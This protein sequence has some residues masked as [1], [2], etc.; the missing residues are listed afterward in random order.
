MY[1]DEIL[2]AGADGRICR[3]HWHP[4]SDQQQKE[5][6]LLQEH[7]HQRRQQ[8]QQE[9]QSMQSMPV[10]QHQQQDQQ[11]KQHKQQ[12]Q[13]ESQLKQLGHDRQQQQQQQQHKSQLESAVSKRDLQPVVSETATGGAVVK[14]SQDAGHAGG[15]EHAGRAGHAGLKCTAEE[16]F[17]DISLVQDVIR[18]PQTKQTLVCGFK[19][20]PHNMCQKAL[21]GSPCVSDLPLCCQRKRVTS[22]DQWNKLPCSCNAVTASMLAKVVCTVFFKHTRCFCLDCCYA[23]DWSAS[24]RA[25]PT[26]RLY[27]GSWLALASHLHCD[28]S[29]LA[30]YEACISI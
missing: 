17:A 7:H 14:A 9:Q 11:D 13:P 25:N 5:Q 22:S 28:R 20:K 26:C 24:A 16:R 27:N 18:D 21:E 1:G 6:Q 23:P 3:Y 29:S 8:Q 10:Q 12:H 15:A 30:A 19:V 4:L 2:T